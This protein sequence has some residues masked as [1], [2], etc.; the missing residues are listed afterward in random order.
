MTKRVKI[1]TWEEMEKELKKKI[2]ELH[3]IIDKQKERLGR[4]EYTYEKQLQ[5]QDKELERRLH[6]IRYLESHCLKVFD[7]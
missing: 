1:K 4:L 2:V 3:N 7:D 5:L 6:I